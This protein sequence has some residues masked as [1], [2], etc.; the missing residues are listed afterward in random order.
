MPSGPAQRLGGG[1]PQPHR[2]LRLDA[3]AGRPIEAL[4]GGQWQ[5]TLLARA[6]VSSPG[7]LLLDE[8]DTHLDTPSRTFL[9]D[10]LAAS[11]AR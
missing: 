11:L 2:Q 9:Y 7:L 1:R 5:R 3:L 8:P 4:S 10:R 6:V